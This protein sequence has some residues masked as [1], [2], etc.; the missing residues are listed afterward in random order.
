MFA[1]NKQKNLSWLVVE[2]EGRVV[3]LLYGKGNACKYVVKILWQK[4][5]QFDPILLLI[6]SIVLVL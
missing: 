2:E 6:G 1:I 3:E 5:K 4:F